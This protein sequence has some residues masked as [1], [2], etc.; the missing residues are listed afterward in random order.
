MGSKRFVAVAWAGA[1]GL[2][3]AAAACGGSVARPQTVPAPVAAPSTTLNVRLANGSIASLALEEYVLAS[4]LAEIAP[5]GSDPDAAARV[6]EVQAILARTYAIASLGRHAR[7]GFDLCATT[8]CQLVDFDRAAR[9]RW[10]P[11]AEVAIQATRGRVLRF[12]SA[13]V[14]A[15]FHA[16]C[17]GY[18]S[19]AGDIW[20]GR[21]QPYLNGG[22][23]DLPDGSA[24]RSWQFRVDR[25]RL[26]EALARDART[27]P[28]AR[29]D[30]IDVFS[31]DSAGRAALVLVAGEREPIVRGEEFRMVM[32]RAFGVSAFP[33]S[34]FD[35]ERDGDDFAFTGTGYGH[36]VG[37]CQ[38]GA[39]ARAAAGA[40]PEDILAFYFPGT[41]LSNRLAPVRTL[42]NLLE[43][44]RTLSNLVEPSRTISNLI[45]P[46]SLHT[47]R[48]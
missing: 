14:L 6:Y 37:L 7:D 18:R 33:S 31:R 5:G 39:I 12:E 24:H 30:R 36:G 15:L 38:R 45:E 32:A 29:I 35:V 43:P 9:S 21:A 28:G 41:T 13:P 46:M 17:G 42:S 22:P 19:A 11:I 1:V 25:A 23:D 16:D 20:G 26:R 34:R 48:Y 47:P 27:N 44:P 2:G 3:L 40:S 10:R 8:H 4:I